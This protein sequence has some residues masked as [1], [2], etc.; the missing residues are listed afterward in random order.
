MASNDPFKYALNTSTIK[1]RKLPLVDE[2]KLVADAGYDGI[3]PWIAEI[4]AYV[5]GGGSLA[6]LGERIADQGLIVAGAI[7]FFEW[8]V[9]APDRRAKGLAEAERNM[10]LVRQLGGSCLAAP[11]FGARED[12]L[13]PDA[14]AERYTDLLDL[15]ERMGVTPL[16]EVWG[17]SRTL[18][19]LADGLYVMAA[20]GRADARMLLD[21]YHLYKAGS[22]AESL[23]FVS[24]EA[25]GLFHVNDY[26]LLPRET[27]T[28]ADRVYPG[29]GTAPLGSIFR[30]LAGNGY[31]GMLSVELFN[32][33]YWKEDAAKVARTALT[34]T[35]EAVQQALA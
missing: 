26:P 27:I 22:A 12:R 21:V 14:V 18:R 30:T 29:D 19:T 11:P 9:D 7:G 1:G 4:D 5:A 32:Q 17:M 16:L 35:R 10:E 20:C 13:D 25:I 24:A 28:D 6:E 31:R 34:R 33:D 15:G 2:V 23:A 8:C 3:E